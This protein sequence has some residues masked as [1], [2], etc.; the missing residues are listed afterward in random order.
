MYA[1]EVDN[2]TLTL[3]VSGYLWHDSLV[4]QD[5]ETKTY[6]SHI[7][8]EAKAGPLKG[9]RLK[10]IPSVMTD[11]E[12][13]SK[14]HPDATVV[15]LSRTSNDYT[16]QFYVQPQR[17]VIGIVAKGQANAWGFDL[18]TKTPVLNEHIGDKPVL[19]AFDRDSATGRMYERKLGDRVLTFHVD[20]GRITDKE[21][22]STWDPV[23]GRALAGPLRGKSLTAMPAIVSYRNVW[24]GFHPNSTIHSS[25]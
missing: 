18:L 23:T 4:M 9:K 20:M 6:W 1:R 25:R 16:R 24:K 2:K 13:W 15:V 5:Q 12:A 14:R 3:S 7:L 11:W 8:G 10:Q 21:S 19:V 22:G 17:F